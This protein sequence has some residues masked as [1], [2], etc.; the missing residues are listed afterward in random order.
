M[1][2]NPA[3]AL[4]ETIPFSKYRV[5]ACV[6][7]GLLALISL[8]LWSAR[9]AFYYMEFAL[10]IFLVPVAIGGGIVSAWLVRQRE[11]RPLFTG[12][13]PLLLMTAVLLPALLASLPFQ[14]PMKLAFLSAKPALEEAV[15]QWELTGEATA[16]EEI[17]AG[18]YSFEGVTSN[19]ERSPEGALIFR[20]KKDREQAFIHS[21]QG[22]EN[23]SYNSGTKGHLVGDW[24]WMCE[25]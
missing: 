10:L 5:P 8:F 9:P 20:F 3:I 15:A 22:I 2:Q 25:D 11:K 6:I 16:G 24:Y 4:K 13:K 1:K 23:L 19:S 12:L 7:P 18:F 14:A 17:T 21:P